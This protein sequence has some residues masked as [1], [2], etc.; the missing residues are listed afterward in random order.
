MRQVANNRALFITSLTMMGMLLAIGGWMGVTTQSAANEARG[1][2]II[3]GEHIA[4][5]SVGDK[6]VSK[7]LES[8][9]ARQIQ[10]GQRIDGIYQKLGE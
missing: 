7:L 4:A 2:R 9:E 10:M 5:E 3:I 1:A 8:V 6:S